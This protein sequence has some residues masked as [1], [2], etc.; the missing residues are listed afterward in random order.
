[1]LYHNATASDGVGFICDVGADVFTIRAYRLK[2]QGDEI[3]L[4]GEAVSPVLAGLSLGL[5]GPARTIQLSTLKATRQWFDHSNWVFEIDRMSLEFDEGRNLYAH[6]ATCHETPHQFL[7]FTAKRLALFLTV[8][9]VE[10]DFLSSGITLV[11]DPRCPVVSNLEF[12]RFDATQHMHQTFPVL[13]ITAPGTIAPD[14]WGSFTIEAKTASGEVYPHTLEVYLE[15]TA[16][17]LPKG[18]L[19][20]NGTANCKLSAQGLDAGDTIKLKAGF[21]YYSGKAEAMIGVA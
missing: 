2:D 12:T 20:L 14:G 4:T 6:T 7:R 21:R 1:M 11:T 8:P 13:A 15:T 10:A 5:V 18:R 16:G 17:Y 9:H 3:V 19:E